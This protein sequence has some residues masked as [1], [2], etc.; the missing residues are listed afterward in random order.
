MF[1][2]IKVLL[3]C[4]LISLA[5][6]AEESDRTMAISISP[7]ALIRTQADVIFQYNITS[8]LSLTLPAHFAYFWPVSLLFDSLS[9]SVGNFERSK[10]PL[11]YGAGL[12]ARLYPTLKGM[13]SGLYLEP[14]LVIDSYQ[15]GVK[16][17]DIGEVEWARTSLVSSI[18]VGWDWFSDSGFYSNIGG[19]IGYS[20][21]ISSNINS[22]SWFKEQLGTVGKWL[23]PD[24]SA[25]GAFA[26]ELDWKIG[27]AW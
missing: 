3:F 12:G 19:G 8:F 17:K 7:V 14:R 26:W 22:P 25:K 5:L 2:S 23:L 9:K 20:Y 1:R 15:I 11:F 16:A 24:E 18:H 4:F 13:N 10:A 6:F 27:Y 21:F